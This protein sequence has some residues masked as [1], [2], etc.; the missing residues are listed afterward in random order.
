M[1]IIDEILLK[2]EFKNAPPVLI[3]I[4][5]SG[6]LHSKWKKIAKYSICI[7]FDADNREMAFAEKET[8][9]FKKLIVFSRVVTDQDNKEIDFYLTKSPFC[10]S[11]LEPDTEQLRDWSFRELFQVEKKIKLK[12]IRITEA[13]QEAKISLVDWF[14][15]DTQGTDLRLFQSLPESIREKVIIAEFEPGIIDGYKGEDKL[16]DTI[17]YMHKYGFYMSNMEVKGVQRINPNYLNDFSGIHKKAL[18]KCLKKS[19]GWAEVTY[20]NR[21][22]TGTHDKRT[23]LLSY[24]FALIEKQFGFA[25]EIANQGF[26]ITNDGYFNELKNYAI[27]KIKNN[28]YKWPLIMTQKAINKILTK[29]NA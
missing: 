8:N 28:N 17:S 29:I 13:L 6:E 14:K 16:Y 26:L 7:A 9:T 18:Q 1:D 2:E 24:V 23:Y 4:G 3:D 5:A 25:I 11:S 21:L 12:A 10:S 27:K 22:K 15:T 20:M 19:P